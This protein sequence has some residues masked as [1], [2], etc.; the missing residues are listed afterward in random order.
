VLLVEYERVCQERD[1]YRR[2]LA[3]LNMTRVVGSRDI[4]EPVRSQIDH[5]LAGVGMDWKQGQAV[6]SIAAGVRAEPESS[7]S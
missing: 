2:A 7:A 5:I 1:D 3:L 6:A 4:E